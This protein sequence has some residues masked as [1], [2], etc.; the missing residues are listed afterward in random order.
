MTTSSRIICPYCGSNEPLERVCGSCGGLLDLASRAATAQDIGPWFLRAPQR[1]FFPGFTHSRLHRMVRDGQLKSDSIVRGPTTGG[2]WMPADRVPGLAQMLGCCHGCQSMV[3]P[4]DQA[5]PRCGVP[6]GFEHQISAPV[7][8][9]D[10]QDASAALELI[11]HAQYR[12]ISR[13]QNQIRFQ[14]IALAIAAGVIFLGG[15]IYFSGILEPDPLKQEVL[16]AVDPKPVLTASDPEENPVS[17]NPAV[18]TPPA[19]VESVALNAA[20][21]S[22]PEAS[23]SSPELE[24][25][26]VPEIPPD[27]VAAIE[28]KLFKQPRDVTPEQSALITRIGELLGIAKSRDRS[29]FERNEAIDDACRLID[30]HLVD[31]QDELMQFRLIAL[32]GEFDR[33]R[34]RLDVEAGMGG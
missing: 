25:D 5:C 34:K 29:A 12:R 23:T 17:T 1:P 20:M 19:P 10:H 2:F 22:T 27:G 24:P 11:K 28:D 26:P 13:L 16:V 31:E 32:R 9:A 21:D 7:V 3:G 4:D 30:D 14:A 18:S 8:A 33:A 6:L 15:V